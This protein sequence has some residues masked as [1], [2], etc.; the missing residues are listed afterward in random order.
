MAAET[1]TVDLRSYNFT[2]F[3]PRR[4]SRPLPRSSKVRLYSSLFRDDTIVQYHNLP[5]E[6]WGSIHDHL[7]VRDLKSLALV[8]RH[9][10]TFAR[11]RLGRRVQS[12]KATSPVFYSFFATH[13]PFNATSLKLRNIILHLSPR[14]K[15]QLSSNGVLALWLQ[16]S[17]H[18]NHLCELALLGTDV[19]YDGACDVL[20]SLPSAVRLRRFVCENDGLLYD[21]WESLC[22]H[23]EDLED[24]GGF[25]DTSG[26]PPRVSPDEFL[27]WF[28]KVRTL[29]VGVRFVTRLRHP[30][31][32]THL[33]VRLEWYTMVPDLRSLSKV[34]GCQVRALHL[35]RKPAVG[36]WLLDGQKWMRGS[37]SPLFVCAHLN[38]PAL[39]Y[40]EV[41]DSVC[42][43]ENKRR[44]SP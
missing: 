30:G 2:F 34:F 32:V 25:F 27:V 5:A 26:A 44:P 29:E 35:V 33:S 38:M 7:P 17:R 4:P 8:N 10:G 1:I 18:L 39:H 16:V 20:G 40:L 15:R 24:F 23:R 11:D 41:R 19:R 43:K 31:G 22:D 28:D 36:G 6:L 14:S 13:L 21:S 37:E 42:P 3:H 9:I 12:M